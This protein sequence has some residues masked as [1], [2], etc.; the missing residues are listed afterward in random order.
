M[1][2]VAS[3]ITSTINSIYSDWKHHFNKHWHNFS[4]LTVLFFHNSAGNQI[5]NTTL[6]GNPQVLLPIQDGNLAH[7][8]SQD[9]RFVRVK[10]TLNFTSRQHMVC[11]PTPPILCVSYY[12]DLF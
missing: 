10:C 3:S 2:L 8:C 4:N 5:N 12:F 1:P 9:V 7:C 11:N 6:P